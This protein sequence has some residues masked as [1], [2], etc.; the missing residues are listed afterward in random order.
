M[1]KLLC[2]SEYNCGFWSLSFEQSIIHPM[3]NNCI[4]YY[5]ILLLVVFQIFTERGIS[6]N[7]YFPPIGSD[8]WVNISYA[9]AG[10]DSTKLPS[11][12]SFLE[13]NNTDAFLVL[14]SGKILYEDYFGDFNPS[15]FS[16]WFSAGKTMTATLIGIAQSEGL[17]AISDS[18]HDYLGRGW[19]Q[20]SESA[21]DLITIKNQMT[22]TTGLDYRID[23]TFCTDP[24]CLKC[25]N[26]PGKEWF[27]HNAPYTRLTDVISNASGRTI[28]TYTRIKVR[29][30]IGMDGFWTPVGYNRFFS[31]TPRSMARFGL[32]FLNG[33]DWNGETIIEDKPYFNSM[34]SPSQDINPS[35]GYLWW[36]NGQSHFRLPGDTVTFQGALIPQ[37]PADAYAALG[38]KSQI[39]LVIPSEQTVIIRTGK[40]PDESLVP[41]NFLR[42]MW[43]RYNDL[44]TS[45][46]LKENLQN[47]FSVY[48]NPV[49]N[50]VQFKNAE[51][52]IKIFDVHGQLITEI[53]SMKTNT[54]G[55]TKGLYYARSGNKTLRFIKI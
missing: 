48:P 53:R 10:I 41:I 54:Q 55:W 23:D 5:T 28:N 15:D 31:S 43:D 32:L 37:A 16:V 22:M 11:L 7:L 33:G 19:T 13:E 34:I 17:L 44:K 29:D 12:T 6:Q 46:S 51:L 24:E 40:D 38:A 3:R 14:R 42:E 36:L 8:D 27:Y 49:A 9:E 4:R 1:F 26:E 18:S 35:Y 25:F 39:I 30:K 20:C 50:D 47:S 2:D 21:E 52:P 45:T